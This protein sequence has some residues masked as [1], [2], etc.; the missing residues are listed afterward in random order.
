MYPF[1]YNETH[2]SITD[3]THMYS[4][5]MCVCVYISYTDSSTQ[6]CMITRL[7]HGLALAFP[8]RLLFLLLSKSRALLRMRPTKEPR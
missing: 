8:L 1:I 3:V 4:I 6:A 5:Y 2:V 7:L